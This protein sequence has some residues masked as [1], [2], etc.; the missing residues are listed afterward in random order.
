MN[1][2]GFT[3]I[4]LL[5]V[6]SVIGMLSSIVL[7][8]LQ[9]ARD[10]GRIASSIIF[11][12][13][14]YRGWGADAIGV[15]N[16]DQANGPATDSG[17]NSLNLNCAGTCNRSSSIKPLSSGYSLDFSAEGGQAN[18]SNYLDSGVFASTKNLSS[19]FT[20]SV[21]VYFSNNS[22]SGMA[23]TL[24]PRL[25]FINFIA[26][27]TPAQFRLGPR[28][29][30]PDNL[31]GYLVNYSVPIGK[32]VHIAYSYDGSNNLRVYIDGK[33][34]QSAAVGAASLGTNAT[35]ITVG[36]EGA[37]ALHFNN[38][39]LDELAIYPN[40]LT[41]DAIEHIYAQGV[42]KHSLAKAD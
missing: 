3:L 34:L 16:F 36:N 30:A 21:W 9:S 40:V 25:S 12:T 15:W 42:I 18:I 27:A 38:G 33:L 22:A 23:Y 7:V 13:S 37:G 14:M 1:K 26:A 19:G 5:V 2:K 24:Y 10:K 35:Q 4:E 32:W 8:S 17:P 31:T 6:I 41:A 28:T 29:G 20:A 39:L 11:S